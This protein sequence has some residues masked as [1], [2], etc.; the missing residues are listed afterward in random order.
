VR[1]RKALKGLKKA[2]YVEIR[3]SQTRNFIEWEKR[4][5]R[6]KEVWRKLNFLKRNCALSGKKIEMS[7][8]F[9]KKLTDHLK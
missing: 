3:K 6:F 9:G 7:K 4:P 8:R 1:I 5:F 2:P